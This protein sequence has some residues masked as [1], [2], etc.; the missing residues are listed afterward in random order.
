MPATS[1]STV[2]LNTVRI[3]RPVRT[4]KNPRESNPFRDTFE[5]AIFLYLHLPPAH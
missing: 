5:A 4:C 3:P 1:R 2:P